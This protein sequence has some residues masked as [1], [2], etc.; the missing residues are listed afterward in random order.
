MQLFDAPTREKCTVRRPR[1][2]TP[3]Q[4][5]VLLND[6]Q[7]VEAACRFAQRILKEAPKTDEGRITFAFESA[8]AR[9]PSPGELK[10]I[11]DLLKHAKAR[12]QSDIEAAKKLIAVG[13]SQKDEKLDPQEHA[14][15][16]V[17]ASTI[18]NL[19]EVLTRE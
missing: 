1:T 17:V 9:K 14:A 11:L 12:Y 3:L 19:D 7:F 2:N 10:V 6:V 8:T 18:L 4:A 16:T 13:E 5:L 15:W